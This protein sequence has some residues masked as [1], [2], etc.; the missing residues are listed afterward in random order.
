[1]LSG[2]N[3]PFVPP[4]SNE[5][6]YRSMGGTG[7]REGIGAGFMYKGGV[8]KD[9]V[10]LRFPRY[11]LVVVIEGSGHYVD[12]RGNKYP[13]EPGSCFQRLPLKS[14]SNYIDPNSEWTEFYLEIG[15][16]LYQALSSMLIIRAGSPVASLQLDDE[17]KW[18]VWNF[19]KALKTV[20]EDKLPELVSQGVGLLGECHR[21][22]HA[23]PEAKDQLLLFEEACRLLGS[24]FDQ[25]LDLKKFC[26]KNGVGYESFRKIFKERSGIAPWKYRVRRRLDMACGMLGSPDIPIAEIASK[27]GY[28]SAY[29]FSAQFKRYT[30][31]SPL[32]F[33]KGKSDKTSTPS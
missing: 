2:K 11:V 16:L 32:H 24:D 28:S 27:L 10:N 20:D 31:T 30:G 8:V 18:L 9:N 33:R 4:K 29:E 5:V 1:M 23:L 7:S 17:L 6:A 21:R 19:V 13:L 22:I 25:P 14:H 12:D 15:P 26:R 3:T